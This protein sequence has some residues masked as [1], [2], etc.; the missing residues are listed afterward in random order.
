MIPP[1]ILGAK[2]LINPFDDIIQRNR[3]INN[4]KEGPKAKDKENIKGKVAKEKPSIISKNINL[5]SFDHDENEDEEDSEQKEKKP[6]KSSHDMLNDPKLSKQPAV[7][8]E[9][10]E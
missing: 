2:I 9:E 4:E 7:S 1:K 10:L 5:L 6:I 3:P 8:L